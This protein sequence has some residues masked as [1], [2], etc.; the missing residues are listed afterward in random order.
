MR[1]AIG[2]DHAGFPLKEL[3]IETVQAMGHEAID[4]GTYSIESVDY[5]DFTVK[6]GKALQS[7]EASRGIMICGS[8]VGAC[9]TAN[10]MRGIFAC[11][12]HDTYSARQGVEHDDMNVLCMG[13]RIVGSEIARELVQAF[14]S[15]V[16]SKDER[17]QRRVSKIRQLEG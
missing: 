7:G 9:I 15:S 11:L 8:G 5:P 1:V 6:V 10:K 16:F 14:L 17:H 4:L 12:C 3:V 2:C 13:A